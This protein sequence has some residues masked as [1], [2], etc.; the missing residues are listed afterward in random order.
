MIARV[1]GEDGKQSL[2]CGTEAIM[3][4]TLA[5]I[6]VALAVLLVAGGLVSL[7]KE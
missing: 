7:C 5:L 3:V 6:G 2:D 4:L 1:V